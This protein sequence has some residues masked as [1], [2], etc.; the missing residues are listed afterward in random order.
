MKILH[1]NTHDINGGAARA[2]YRLHCALNKF[3]HQS[4]M[5]VRD[6]ISDDPTVIIVKNNRFLSYCRVFFRRVANKIIRIWLNPQSIFSL[7]PLLPTNIHKIVNKIDP[8]IVHL[9]WVADGFLNL[10]ELIGI[11]KPIIW[12]LHD[13]WV[14]TGGCHINHNCFRFYSSCGACPIINSSNS[15]DISYKQHQIKYNTYS[16]LPHL[17]FNGVSRWTTQQ[18]QSASVSKNHKVINLANPL[19]ISEFCLTEKVVA[20]DMLKLDPSHKYILFGAMSALSDRNKGADLLIEALE[21][22]SNK[23]GI[24]LLI[25]GNKVN[26]TWLNS[27]DTV[28]LG[29]ISGNVIL[30]QIY[31][32]ADVMIVPSRQENLANTIMESLACGTPV[33]A[34]DI[35]GNS[36]M[37]EHKKNGYLAA[38]FDCSDLANGIEWVLHNNDYENLR[39]NA[40]MKVVTT[41]SE[42]VVIP[43]YLKT[44]EKMIKGIQN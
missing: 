43:Q 16:Q 19:N 9:H 40:R 3:G 30:N 21:K 42:E 38:P 33:V 28:F 1:I 41:F 6:K 10:N 14:L 15:N 13:E 4:Y 35:G 17:V 29:F 32:A 2:V 18:I 7:N 24:T 8:D 44:Y 11:R 31:N 22:F 5:L 12:T 27:F 39:Q 20:R 26:E 23:L 34:F 36:D 37:I 25:F